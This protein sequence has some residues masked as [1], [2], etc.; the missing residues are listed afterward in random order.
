L[1]ELKK[2]LRRDVQKYV[3]EWFHFHS[4]QRWQQAVED[5][6]QKGKATTTTG[7]SVLLWSY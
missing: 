3:P 6:G 5:L 7:V 4:L 2:E 1:F